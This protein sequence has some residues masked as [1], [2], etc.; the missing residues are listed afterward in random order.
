MTVSE[1]TAPRRFTWPADYYSSP[2]VEPVVPAGVAYGCGGAA[3]LVLIVVFVGG[4]LVT[5]GGF[6][7]FMDFTIGMSVG[8]LRAQYGPDVPAARK[9]S[10]DAEIDRMRENLRQEKV[11]MPALQPFLRELSAAISDKRVT[12]A[13][14][15]RLE[16]A[17]R[18]VNATAKRR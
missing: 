4:A 15:A 13:E 1:T 7:E 5:S 6:A 10:L 17:V 8:E 18:K 16:E 12:A 3:L 14:A 11:A 9:A 2:T